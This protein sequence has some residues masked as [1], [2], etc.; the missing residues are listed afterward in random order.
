MVAFFLF[1]LLRKE[2]NKIRSFILV[3]RNYNI[4]ID[5]I[6]RKLCYLFITLLIRRCFNISLI[7]I[8]FYILYLIEYTPI[9]SFLISFYS[10]SLKKVL[11]EHGLL[12]SFFIIMSDLGAFIY[13]ILPPNIPGSPNTPGPS[14]PLGGPGGPSGP[15]GPPG[16]PSGP[17]GPPGGPSGPPGGPGTPGGSGELGGP[18]RESNR[19][20]RNSNVENN[21]FEPFSEDQCNEYRKNVADKLRQLFINK[22]S[23]TILNMSNPAHADKLTPL[24]HNM[25]CKQILDTKSEF[26]YCKIAENSSGSLIYTGVIGIRL[27]EIME[28][29]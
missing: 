17:P 4:I 20:N 26:L 12:M 23:R 2:N 22:P 28:N 1:Y 7:L 25:I 14:G 9:G 19:F 18:N 21:N 16:G 3:I 11:L 5:V 6:K 13:Y 27:L 24:D 10:L 29:P 15:P 8:L